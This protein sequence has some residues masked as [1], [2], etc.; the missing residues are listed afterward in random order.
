MP[1][2]SMNVPRSVSYSMTV[3]F[4]VSVSFSLSLTHIAR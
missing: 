1:F 2:L 4:S 3:L